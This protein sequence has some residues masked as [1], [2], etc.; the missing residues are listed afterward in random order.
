MNVANCHYQ[1]AMLRPCPSHIY[2]GQVTISMFEVNKAKGYADSTQY[3]PK[4]KPKP[5]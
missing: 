2:R 3:A 4:P 1:H 5:L